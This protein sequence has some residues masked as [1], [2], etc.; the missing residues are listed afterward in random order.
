MAKVKKK[1]KGKVGKPRKVITP[2]QMRQ[3]EEYA[4]NNCLNGTIEGL[5]DWPNEFIVRRA[6]IAKKLTKKRQEGKA[7]LRKAQ[8]EKALTDK[9]TTMQIWLGKNQL[10]QTDK[11]ETR[12]DVGNAPAIVVIGAN[13]RDGGS[14]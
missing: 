9:D 13:S 7:A 10:G 2:E 14:V 1:A 5:M 3:A 8:H 12:L 11:T 6:D 4:Y